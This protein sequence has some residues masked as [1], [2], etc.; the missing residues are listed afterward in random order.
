MNDL[1][2]ELDKALI[3]YGFSYTKAFNE[4][5]PHNKDKWS[6]ATYK[7]FNLVAER[8]REIEQ[9]SKEKILALITQAR[10]DELNKLK[11]TRIHFFSVC[12]YHATGENK[13]F[14]E[15]LIDNYKISTYVQER[16]AELKGESK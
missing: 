10:I 15:L 9:E 14:D 5:D 8:S 11:Q 16:I 1:D 2:K 13:E 12:G 7:T 4:I 3:K 6:N